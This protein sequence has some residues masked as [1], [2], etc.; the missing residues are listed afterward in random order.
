[1]VLKDHASYQ[2]G[3]A[4]GKPAI[5]ALYQNQ[6]LVWYIV[7][8]LALVGYGIEGSCIL[9]GWYDSSIPALYQYQA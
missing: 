7:W 2:V 1:M 4:L 3:M 9:P 5:P 6:A 8:S